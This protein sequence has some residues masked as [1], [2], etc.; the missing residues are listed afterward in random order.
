[1]YNAGTFYELT[2]R[3]AA[4]KLY[5]L[6]YLD[7]VVTE[8]F[9]A[10]LL[11]TIATGEFVVLLDDNLPCLSLTELRQPN[12]VLI[13][14]VLRVAEG[15][16]MTNTGCILRGAKKG[17]PRG[18]SCGEAVFKSQHLIVYRFCPDV[19]TAIAATTSAHVANILE[20]Q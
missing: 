11:D 1:M 20:E 14:A 19:F 2:E 16:T 3:S 17:K 5:L 10:P 12:G 18:I 13:G 7:N 9:V 4:V 8:E 15:I 6:P